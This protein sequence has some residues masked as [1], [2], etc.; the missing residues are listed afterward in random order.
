MDREL[1]RQ[2]LAYHGEPLFNKLKCEQTENPDFQAV[3]SDL[4]KATYERYVGKL[5][6]LAPHVSFTAAP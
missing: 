3:V 2:C 6:L 1:L 4:C 5:S